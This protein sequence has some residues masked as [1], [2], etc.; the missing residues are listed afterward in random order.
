M[1]ANVKKMPPSKR[2]HSDKYLQAV[3]RVN[4]NVCTQE[5]THAHWL[6]VRMDAPTAGNHDMET[7]V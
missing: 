5:C 4:V 7:T 2:R 6:H 3:P 1:N